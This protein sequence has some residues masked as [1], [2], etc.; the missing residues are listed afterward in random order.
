MNKTEL[1]KMKKLA[2]QGDVEAQYQLGRY[3]DN[4]DGKSDKKDT[5]EAVKWYS[6]AA[7][8][9]HVKAQNN[10]GVCYLYG[11]GIQKNLQEALNWFEKAAKAGNQKAK[12]SASRVYELLENEKRQKES[13]TCATSIDSKDNSLSK[14]SV[15]DAIGMIAKLV[16]LDA[17]NETVA[18]IHFELGTIQDTLHTMQESIERLEKAITTHKKKNL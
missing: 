11:E 9:G 12:E 3:Y 1:K 16:M 14:M 10:L 5:V 6:K 18:D 2:E 13:E 4:V 7:E 17:I 8:Q 15:E